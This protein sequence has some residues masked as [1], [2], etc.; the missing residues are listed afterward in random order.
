[1][2]SQKVKKSQ[3]SRLV[4]ICV[5]MVM[6]FTTLTAY[7]ADDFPQELIDL[8]AS[9]VKQLPTKALDEC[10]K[11]LVPIYDIEIMK[12]FQFVDTT[13]QNK[14][15]TS[16]LSNIAIA[17]YATYKEKLQSIYATL[18]PEYSEPIGAVFGT[19]EVSVKTYDN[20]FTSYQQCAVITETYLDVA[21]QHL[22]DQL[23]NNVAKKKTVMLL[24]KYQS[25]N[26]KLRDLNMAIA[27]MY[28]MFTTFKEKLPFFV[29]NCQ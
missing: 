7:A 27:Q 24:E 12:F 22:K 6:S 14:S 19:E 10:K 8:Q 28:S 29:E 5:V 11:S 9:L 2:F 18:S 23:R 17:G 26:E 15:S 20:Q 21:K 13:L 3:F 16:S 25:I 1:M 4:A